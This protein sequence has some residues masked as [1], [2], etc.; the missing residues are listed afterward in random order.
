MRTAFVIGLG[1]VL[2]ATPAGAQEEYLDDRS[3]PVSLVRSLYNAI[4]SK[5]YARAWSYFAT[6]PADSL[7][8]Y[9]AGYAD[10][11]A[12]ELRTGSVSQE[13]AAGS[14]YFRLPVAIEAHG[15]DGG[16]RVFSGC[17]EMRMANPEIA[18]DEFTPL[19]IESGRFS[20]SD[21][22]LDLSVPASCDSPEM[23][24]V[25]QTLDRAI[26]LY[27]DAFA[28]Q[29]DLMADTGRDELIIGDHEIGFRYS[30]DSAGA[31]M[32]SA[33][34]FQFLCYRG[35]YNESHVFVY[36]NE[37]DEL[38]PLSFAVPELDIRYRDD[39]REGPV[40]AIYVIGFRTQAA[41]VNSEFAPE[42]GILIS[43]EK[44]RGVADA[45]SV[46]NWLFRDGEFSLVSFDVDAT[47]DGEINSQTVLDYATGP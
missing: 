1:L 22:P 28:D 39:N 15:T 18:T 11:S 24:P 47:Y 42:S 43:W 34:L 10:T 12:V 7:D 30:Y 36:A 6:P 38:R 26:A 35:A 4:N 40:D 19:Q 9:A 37:R 23:E 17:Y 13:G 46:G 31:P 41:L 20:V 44:W 8:A 27:R 32:R 5:E 25:D 16:S 45:S 2:L 21:N 3:G 33:R 14:I 29:C